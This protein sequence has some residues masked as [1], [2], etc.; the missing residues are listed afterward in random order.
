[1]L[2][3]T[4]RNADKTV[5]DGGANNNAS[6]AILPLDHVACGRMEA[7][8][9]GVFLIGPDAAGRLRLQFSHANGQGTNGN[10]IRVHLAKAHAN[11]LVTASMRG[12]QGFRSYQQ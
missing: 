4:F 1:M 11:T 2:V 8:D 10:L 5:Y 12:D 7:R 6:N 3:S 9:T